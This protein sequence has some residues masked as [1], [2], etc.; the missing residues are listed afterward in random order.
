MEIAMKYDFPL[1]KNEELRIRM[2]YHTEVK[3]P[4]AGYSAKCAC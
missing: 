2:A 1:Q 4:C 3:L